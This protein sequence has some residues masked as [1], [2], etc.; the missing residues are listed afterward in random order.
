[1]IAYNRQP[2]GACLAEKT[3]DDVY[4]PS[5]V[6]HIV[7]QAGNVLIA[8]SGTHVLEIHQTE[9]FRGPFRVR[10]LELLPLS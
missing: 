1:M 3:R 5:H 4:S 7:T 2:A 6:E 10:E 9:P 8:E